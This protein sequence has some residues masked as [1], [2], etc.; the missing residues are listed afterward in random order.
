MSFMEAPGAYIMSAYVEGGGADQTIS[1][2][3]MFDGTS[4]NRVTLKSSPQIEVNPSGAIVRLR[5]T[6]GS[7]TIGWSLQ[8]L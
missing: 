7:S 2:L 8:R 3:I 1:V 5:R 4:S 6:S